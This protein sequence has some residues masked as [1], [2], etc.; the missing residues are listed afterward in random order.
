MYSI[1]CCASSSAI[2]FWRECESAAVA[3]VSTP[4]SAVLT[5]PKMTIANRVSIS[6][7]PASRLAARSSRLVMHLIQS[8]K[9][10]VGINERNLVP[11]YRYKGVPISVRAFRA[12]NPASTLFGRGERDAGEKPGASLG[13]DV[14]R[15]TGARRYSINHPIRCSAGD[16]RRFSDPDALAGPRSRQLR[17]CGR[18]APAA[19]PVDRPPGL[20]LH[21]LRARDRLVRQHPARLLPRSARP[22]S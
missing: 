14:P 17:Q 1:C 19:A 15:R 10:S 5:V 22:L 20:A 16:E 3:E 8:T 13:K 7:K 18:R 11:Q 21:E 2:V 6:V 12:W 9:W 4:M